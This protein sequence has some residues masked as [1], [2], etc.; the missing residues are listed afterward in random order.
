MQAFPMSNR[1]DLFPLPDTTYGT[2]ELGT[3]YFHAPASLTQVVGLENEFYGGGL[4]G[5]GY[6]HLFVPPLECTSLEENGQTNNN[7]ATT[8]TT[9]NNN[10][11]NKISSNGVDGSGNYWGGE[12]DA[13]DLG[14]LMEDVSFPFLDFQDE[15][16]A[17]MNF[18]PLSLALPLSTQ[19]CWKYYKMHPSPLSF[20]E[21]I[22]RMFY[23]L[24]HTFIPPCNHSLSNK[25]WTDMIE[26]IQS[27]LSLKKSFFLLPALSLASQVKLL[28]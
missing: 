2:A 12:R 19:R 1:Y 3:T 28:W 25:G 10:D 20:V 8:T 4:I 15:W 13:W 14:E 23:S 24:N 9:R 7:A 21:A 22:V 5:G 27:S 16:L 6:D 26:T 11:V 17:L 18:L